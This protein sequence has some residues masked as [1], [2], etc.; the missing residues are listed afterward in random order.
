MRTQETKRYGVPFVWVVLGVVLGATIGT[1]VSAA[2]GVPGAAVLSPIVSGVIG[3]ASALV[4]TEL[5]ARRETRERQARV[6]E[7]RARELRTSAAEHNKV[8]RETTTSALQRLIEMAAFSR[9]EADRESGH[10]RSVVETKF[11]DVTLALDNAAL[12]GGQAFEKFPEMFEEIAQNSLG[13]ASNYYVRKLDP[14]GF[15]DLVKE[16]RLVLRN[17]I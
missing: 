7:D 8:L 6:E 16:Y 14:V 11:A 9:T 10:L 2:I 17:S 1:V 12:V 4:A 5:S 15:Q 3:A 13:V